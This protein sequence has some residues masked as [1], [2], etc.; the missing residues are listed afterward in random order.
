MRKYNMANRERH[1][2]RGGATWEFTPAVI[3]DAAA[4]LA[5]DDYKDSPLGLQRS[6]T[7]QLD[8][9]VTYVAG[10]RLTAT[11]FYSVERIKFDLT[12]YLMGTLNLANPAQNWSTANRDVIHTVGAKLDWN[13]LPDVLKL[14]AGYH[15]SD[16]TSRIS[17]IGSTFALL[18]TTSPLPDIRDVTHNVNLTGEYKVRPDTTLRLG[19]TLQRNR[20]TDW[21]YGWSAAPV[22]QLLGSGIVS[23]R[24]TAHLAWISARYDF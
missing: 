20:T 13:A 5:E 19:Y 10:K 23:P 9:S 7:V 18:M 22:A 15:L 2:L 16:G 12:G 6:E 3:F 14:G 1:E 8:A 17:S 4:F 21:S 24:Y 11:G